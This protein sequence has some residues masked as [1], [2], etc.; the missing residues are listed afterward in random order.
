M[1]TGHNVDQLAGIMLRSFRGAQQAANLSGQMQNTYGTIVD[2]ED[3]DEEG[4]VRVTLDE[5]NPEFLQGKD[6]EQ[7][8]EATETDWIYPIVPMKGK[9]PK[10]LVGARVPI[11]PR[12]GDPNRLNFGD[13][14]YDPNEFKKAKQ[15]KNS[16]MTR[17]PCYPAG[18]LPPA[19]EE[20]VGCM[21]VELGGPQGFDWLMV[22]LNR[23]GYKWVRH[24]DRL[25]YHTGQL[26]DN[27]P[28]DASS[29]DTQNR[30][31]DDIIVTT[32]SPLEGSD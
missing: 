19:S 31:Y 10:A 26:P 8:G 29:N 16:A 22:C 25:H 4:R 5:V 17:L 15:P 2:V 21:I 27:D 24:A 14:V 23:G 13:P 18:E 28:G 20:N 32:D 7:S 1:S 6:F 30:T 9:Q 12:N 3:P 11:I